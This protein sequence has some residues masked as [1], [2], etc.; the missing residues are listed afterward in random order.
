M[1]TNRSKFGYNWAAYKS[2]EE[3]LIRVTEYVPLE[4]QQYDVYSFKL[5]DIILRSCSHIDSL[6]KDT[7]RH[8]DFSG[9]LNQHK[10]RECKN[11][12]N[13]NKNRR[14]LK[15]KVGRP[16]KNKKELLNAR[17]SIVFTEAEK[18][19]IEKIVKI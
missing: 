1:N 10:I 15:N 17:V 9:H 6:L 4:T 19:R 8:Q 14:M 2:I 16:K 11:I 5:A 12:L 7:I 18:K 13:D 3:D